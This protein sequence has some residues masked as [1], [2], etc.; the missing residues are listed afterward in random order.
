[1]A[2]VCGPRIPVDRPLPRHVD[3]WDD[4]EAVCA[5]FGVTALAR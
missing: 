3:T 5:A 2:T 4:D 1:M